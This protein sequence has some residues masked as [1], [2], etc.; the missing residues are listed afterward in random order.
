MTILTKHSGV[1][2]SRKVAY[3]S[4]KL[5][6][7]RFSAEIIGLA[8]LFRVLLYTP[9]RDIILRTDYEKSARRLFFRDQVEL[10]VIHYVPFRYRFYKLRVFF[11]FCADERH[12]VVRFLAVAQRT[13]QHRDVPVVSDALE[14][15]HRY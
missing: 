4:R 10:P 6:L 2:L 5:L 8:Q 3:Q 11:V 15:L 14:I 13:G 12:H 1:I 9:H 7:R